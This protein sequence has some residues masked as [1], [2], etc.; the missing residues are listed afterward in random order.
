MSTETPSALP[1][2]SDGAVDRMERGLFEGIRRERD[3]RRARRGRAWLAAAAAAG[4]V[5]VAAVVGP[6]VTGGLAG[7]T[8]DEAAVA[9]VTDSGGFDGTDGET[10]TVDGGAESLPDEAGEPAPGTDADADGGRELITSAT[11]GLRVDDVSEA[12]EQV[13][14]LAESAGGYVESMRVGANG[15]QVL[16]EGVDPSAGDV[17]TGDT[18]VLPPDGAWVQVRVPSDALTGSITGMERI[19][20]VTSST[21]ARRDVTDQAVDLRARVASAEASVERLTELMAQSGSVSDLIAAESALAERQAELEAYRGQLESLEGRVAMSSLTVHLEPAR[22]PVD[23]DPTGF[24]DGLVAGW[25]ALVASVNGVVIGL[26]FLL[27][28]LLVPTIAVGAIWWLRR[29]RRSHR[30]PDDP[31]DRADPA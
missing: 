14:A 2:L 26:G 29:M 4:V 3:R 15:T 5:V 9:P 8:S 13:A 1:E 28:W 17:M 12:A 20:E 19:G 25:D 30:Q 10:G 11:V 31:A 6:A 21:L 24:G 18:T 16:S 22:E 23:A 27:P 7:G